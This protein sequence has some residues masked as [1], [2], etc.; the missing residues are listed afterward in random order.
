MGERVRPLYS[1]VIYIVAVIPMVLTSCTPS[2]PT[3]QPEPPQSPLLGQPVS[4]LL[5]TQKGKEIRE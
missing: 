2:V 5:P 3:T 4:Y 1:L